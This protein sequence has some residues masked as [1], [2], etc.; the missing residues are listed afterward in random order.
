[1]VLKTRK[2]KFVKMYALD[3]DKE[4]IPSSNVVD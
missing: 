4:I 3:L 1:M 2:H